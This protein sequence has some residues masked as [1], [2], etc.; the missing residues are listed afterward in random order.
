MHT[1]GFFLELPKF[2]KWKLELCC[3]PVGYGFVFSFMINVREKFTLIFASLRS[4]S[5]NK[6]LTLRQISVADTHIQD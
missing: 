4:K 3:G 6:N 1:N 5:L 2:A